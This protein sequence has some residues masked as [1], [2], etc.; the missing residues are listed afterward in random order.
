MAIMMMTMA[1]MMMMII[2]TSLVVLNLVCSTYILNGA[3]HNEI[4]M[5]LYTYI[6]VNKLNRALYYMANFSSRVK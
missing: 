5:V 1:M 4:E 2:V 6:S 3:F